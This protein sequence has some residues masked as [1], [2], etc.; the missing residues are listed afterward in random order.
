MVGENNPRV[1][2]RTITLDAWRSP[3]DGKRGEADLHIDLVF[4]ERGRV[5]GVGAPVRFRLSLRR[6][7][8]HILRDSENIIEINRNSVRR[9]SIPEPTKKRKIIKKDSMTQIQ[10]KGDVSLTGINA[11][12]GAKARG[13]VAVTETLTESR[14][15]PALHVTHWP[16]EN[17]YSFRI[18]TQSNSALIGSP[19][20]AKDS[21]MKLQDKNYNRNRGESPEIRIE[22]RCLREDF[23]IEDIEFTD[24]R[25]PS[26][27]ALT[28]SK[29]VAVE[30]YIR[31]ELARAGFDCGDLSEPFTE[32]VLAD[33]VPSVQS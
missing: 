28:R 14:L 20:N 30:Q 1:F 18:E 21:V 11:S 29:Q 9:N 15:D 3:F 4:G 31:D 8:I 13:R 33:A 22:I 19:W 32:I 27:A 24:S 26:W 23:I 6:A 10:V 12:A 17:G 5:G 16:T 25:F 7:E 2:A